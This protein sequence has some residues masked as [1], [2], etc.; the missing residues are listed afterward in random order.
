MSARERLARAQEALVLALGTGAPVPAGFDAARVH[1]SAR[2]LVDKRRRQV[3][4]AWPLLASA[5]GP[6]FRPRFEAWARQH[7]MEVEPSALA[8]GR[9]FAASLEAAGA[10]PATLSPLLQDFDM[11]WRLTEAGELVPRRGLVLSLRRVGASRRWRL[12]LRLPGG[13]GF[14]WWGA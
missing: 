3:E 10:L 1:A 8:D 4:R 2:T 6:D 12:A 5:L 9:R 11:H 13:R 14:A 7:P